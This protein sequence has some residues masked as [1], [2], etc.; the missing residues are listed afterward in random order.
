[1]FDPP[2]P[3]QMTILLDAHC[4]T[5]MFGYLVLQI[6]TKCIFFPIHILPQAALVS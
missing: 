6:Q 1:M 2:P 4:Q 5:S 3:K